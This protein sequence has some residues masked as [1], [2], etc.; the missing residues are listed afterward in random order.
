M[1]T[2]VQVL[3]NTKY[4]D[5]ELIRVLI[6]YIRDNQVITAIKVI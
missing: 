4:E 6:S 3:R 5:P 2:R 1:G